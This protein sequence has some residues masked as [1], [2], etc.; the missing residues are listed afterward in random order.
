MGTGL[1][2]DFGE[3]LDIRELG[4]GDMVESFDMSHNCST[5]GP[6]AWVPFADDSVY[7][8]SP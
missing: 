2:S 8:G 5:M 3:V 6:C 4:L 1:F 7:Y